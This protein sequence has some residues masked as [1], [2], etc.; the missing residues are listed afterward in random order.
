MRPTKLNP[1]A[2]VMVL[3][4]L[5]ASALL[6]L[7][8]KNR[9]ELRW[10]AGFLPGSPDR[11]GV[12]FY[13]RGCARC[14][15]VAGV[16]GGVAPDLAR[17]RLAPSDLAELAGAM[18]NHAPGM[19]EEMASRGFQTPELEP[20][21]TADL[22]AFLFVAG[23]LEEGGD[24]V[25]GESVLARKRC[26][27]C[28][29]TGEREQRIGPDLARW[30][31]SVNPILW[32]QLLWNHAPAME[33]AMRREDIAWPELSP[34]EVVD[35]MAFL[36]GIGT[37]PRQVP[38]LP[39][40]PWAGQY[41]FRA[42]CQ[43]CHRVEGEGGDIGPDLGASSAP[44]KLSGL[45]ASLWNHAPGMNGRMKE[46][47][48]ERPSFSEQEMA[49]L[50]TYLFAIRYFELRGD[51][52]A[53]EAVYVRNCGTC[54]GKAGEGGVGPKLDELGARASVTFMTSTL[55]NHGPEMYQEMRSRGLEWPRFQ[56]NE[57]R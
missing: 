28:H 19:W 42:H 55:W 5:L 41:L 27:D 20:R 6:M 26:R 21:D 38:P 18:W 22:M 51:R 49:D 54:H 35:M 2:V 4:A 3:V 53:G 36:R 56:G 15:A 39:G 16:G 29:T 46:L 10:Q 7:R 9:T 43:R 23:Y 40:D 17:V 14:H 44:R 12:L 50:I 24:P 13:D 45:A 1:L 30:S 8:E 52:D 47:E 57:M 34:E 31:S 37:G 33:Q 11:G 25:R 48:V 32:A